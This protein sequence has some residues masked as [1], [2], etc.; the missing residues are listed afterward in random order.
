MVAWRGFIL[1][2]CLV[3]SILKSEAKQISGTVY[4]DNWCSLA[5]NG[6][7]VAT[8][9]M[10]FTPHQAM[11]VSF[12]VAD[13]APYTLAIRAKDWSDPSTGY[14]Y[15]ESD[16]PGIGG[17]GLKVKLDDGTVSSSAWKCYLVSSGPT[18]AS[19][20]KGCS[21]SNYDACEVVTYA[22]PAG[23][24]DVDF[25]DSKWPDAVEFT[26]SETGWGRTPTYDTK[27][28][29]C[30][31]MT[32]PV[33]GE[34]KSPNYLK[35]S[36]DECVAPK[37][38][39]WGKASFIWTS[40]LYKDNEV[41][42]R[43]EASGSSSSSTSSSSSSSS[44]AARLNA[45][46]APARGGRPAA[47]AEVGNTRSTV[48]AVLLGAFGAALLSILATLYCVFPW[49]AALKHKNAPETERLLRNK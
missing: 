7:I 12:T 24:T 37:F 23:W 30:C 10:D 28:G 4:C 27:T 18:A 36:A 2:V 8:D 44:A 1:L 6:E 19:Q 45:P 14:E 33:T 48:P 29:Q 49:S 11:S 15:M 38:L 3:H 9:P 20:A 13:D 22:E 43:F 21:E 5:V 35:L 41:L 40:D 17:G 16:H 39:D 46:A 26:D 34:D 47:F 32:D 31:C 42:C 25:D